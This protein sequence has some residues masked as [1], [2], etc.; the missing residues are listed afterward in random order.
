MRTYINILCI[1]AVATIFFVQSANADCFSNLS[2]SWEHPIGGTWIFDSQKAKVVVNS[3]NYGPAAKQITEFKVTSC[4][5]NQLNYKITRA[6]LENAVNPSFTYDKN[7]QSTPDA[8]DWSKDYLQPYEISG[9]SIKIGNY[10][11]TKQ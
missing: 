2:G 7:S 4:D 8:F 5:N 1:S 6:A 11:Y 9:R 10:T 3:E